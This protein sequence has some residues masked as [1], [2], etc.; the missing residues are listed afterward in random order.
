VKDQDITVLLGITGDGKSTIGNAFGGKKMRFSVDGDLELADG[1]KGFRVMVGGNSITSHPESLMAN[2]LGILFD[3]PG[4]EDTEGAVTDL[5]N[6]ALMKQLLES[7]R[8]VK[9]VLTISEGSIESG[10]RAKALKSIMRYIQMFDKR[11]LEESV[12]LLINKATQKAPDKWLR[13]YL[14]PETQFAEEL[15]RKK[16]VQTL[17]IIKKET[18]LSQLYEAAE[19]GKKGIKALKETKIGEVNISMSLK[20]ET[21]VELARFF[22]LQMFNQL[23]EVIATEWPRQLQSFGGGSSAFRENKA[24]I[25]KSYSDILDNNQVIRLLRP[26]GKS[27]YQVVFD[28]LVRESGAFDA[29]FKTYVSNLEVSEANAAKEAAKKAEL[30][31]LKKAEEQKR[32]AE[33]EREKTKEAKIRGDEEAAKAAK[34]KEAAALANARAEKAEAEKK[35]AEAKAA[36]AMAL[37]NCCDSS[38]DDDCVVM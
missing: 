13:K 2:E 35:A 10:G 22:Q 37:I 29:E 27:Q 18:D 23:Q 34:E 20:P 36:E 8:S 19:K 24:A 1:V 3:L 14:T 17:P 33:Q 30:E 32:I 21:Q 28:E 7:A 31:A 26:L 11:F 9:V 25:L 4:F 6:A 15:L 16:R 5:V 38:S 12:M